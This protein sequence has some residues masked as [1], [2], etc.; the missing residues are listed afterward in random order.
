MG[1]NIIWKLKWFSVEKFVAVNIVKESP[2]PLLAAV[3]CLQKYWE[4]TQLRILQLQTLPNT[5]NYLKKTFKSTI[6]LV[7]DHDS[8][9][10]HWLVY[11][12]KYIYTMQPVTICCPTIAL[13]FCPQLCGLLSQPRPGK[14]ECWSYYTVTCM[15]ASFP[16]YKLFI[17]RTILYQYHAKS[18]L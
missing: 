17:V 18:V 8:K 12:G 11:R 1:V 6:H 2:K 3:H 7:G 16:D 9:H 5:S 4:A 10:H 15:S 13:C 14:W